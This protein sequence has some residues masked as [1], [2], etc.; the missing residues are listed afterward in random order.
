MQTRKPPHDIQTLW[1]DQE[2]EGTTMTL[3]SIHAASKK[4]QS[5]VRARN[6]R[7]LIGMVSVVLVFGLY[8]WILP[9]WMMK[10]GSVLTIIAALFAT[11]QLHK[12]A[13]AQ[14]FAPSPGATIIE[15]HRTELVRQR[16]A[17]KSVGLW[18]IAPFVP[19]MT[20]MM[21]GRYFQSHAPHRAVD[22]DH[23]VIILGTIIVAL[24]FGIVWLLN[25]WVAERLQRQ[26]DELDR[27]A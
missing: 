9:G 5:R 4:L 8:A 21:L 18:Y 24:V 3:E 26:I 14:P 7:E 1:C 17:L 12:R 10:A 13:G 11:W 22:A 6:L 15:F 25:R 27:L 2:L 19:G 16:D 23:L 20:L